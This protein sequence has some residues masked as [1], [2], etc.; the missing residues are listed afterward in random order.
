MRL[1]SRPTQPRWLATRALTVSM[2]QVPE[3]WQD[4][5]GSAEALFS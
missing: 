3:I 2:S 4:Y 5:L 1:L